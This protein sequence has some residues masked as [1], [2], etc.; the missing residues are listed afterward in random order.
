[1]T[2]APT[3][4][5]AHGLWKALGRTLREDRL[6][7]AVFALF[8]GTVVIYLLPIL[9]DDRLAVLSRRQLPLLFLTLTVLALGRDLRRLIYPHERAFW[10]DLTIAFGCWW[11]VALLLQLWP[12]VDK[13][14]WVEI[15]S[16]IGYGGLYI[17]M[18]L[19]IDREPHRRDRWR[20]TGL[21]RALAWPTATVF[22]GGLVVYFV[23]V[24]L[25]TDP[26]EYA[27]TTSMLLYL[28]LDLY[29]TTKL[30]V[31]AVRCRT[32]RWRLLY[33]LLAVTLVSMSIFDL[34]E[35]LTYYADVT[36]TW[37]TWG[38][39]W[40]LP[41][42]LLTT[43]ARLRHHRMPPASSLAPSAPMLESLGFP[44]PSGR[45]LV[46]GLAFALLHF[47]IYSLGI[48]G[49]ESETAREAVVCLW[50]ALL[51][52]IALVQHWLLENKAR[53]LWLERTRAEELA[54]RSE[55]DLA[56][57][58]ERQS[59]ARRLRSA[60][61]RFAKLF[62]ASTAAMA[63]VTTADGVVADVNASFER[64]TGQDRDDLVARPAA[65]VGIWDEAFR[66]EPGDLAAAASEWR[67]TLR[68]A[69]GEPTRVRFA[70]E[71]IELDRA[72]CRLLIGPQT[73]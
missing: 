25:W 30:V 54:R 73:G 3:S 19:A 60:E 31:L 55:Q 64:W 27:S 69:S 13:P 47:T 45:T 34:A 23:L 40:N 70:V 17:A 53:R 9:G 41:F 32:R 66:D 7:Q 2:E 62:Q 59:F 56:L 18:I 15:V 50:L 38:F 52:S 48:F 49:P 20:P 5:Q 63:V 43:A 12:D 37:T 33:G 1:M 65:E 22:V 10:I 16:E 28:V 51:G 58:R 44:G 6:L 42:V 67:T 21:E 61:D 8:A 39:L 46:S 71:P 4:G 68:A 36:W 29:L 24:P 26:E 11:A 14:G 35:G 72:S 57:V